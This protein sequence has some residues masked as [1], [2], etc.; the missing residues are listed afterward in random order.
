LEAA[1]MEEATPTEHDQYGQRFVVDLT[2][3]GPGGQSRVR[4]AWII[5]TGEDFPR[6]T[7]CFV[8]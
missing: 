5:R 1:K 7:S 8:I 4:S 2:L 3:T 6:F